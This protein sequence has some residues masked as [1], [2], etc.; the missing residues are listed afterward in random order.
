MA[1]TTATPTVAMDHSSDTVITLPKN[2]IKLLVSKMYAKKELALIDSFLTIHPHIKTRTA[3]VTPMLQSSCDRS[4]YDWEVEP[5]QYETVP[6]K[7]LGIWC[8]YLTPSQCLNYGFNELFIG[9]GSNDYINASITADTLAG[10]NTSNLMVDLDKS[11]SAIAKSIIKGTINVGY[12]FIDE[13]F[14]KGAFG[15]S[16]YDV[17]PSLASLIYSRNNNS[18]LFISSYWAPFPSICNGYS[19][20]DCSVGFQ[21]LFGL[22]SNIYVMSDDYYSD[23]CL[24]TTGYWDAFQNSYHSRNISN[25]MN[26][27][28]N[29]GSNYGYPPCS[30]PKSSDWSSLFGHANNYGMNNIWLYALQD[31]NEAAVQKF[32]YAAWTNGFV[33]NLAKQ[34]FIEYKCVDPCSSCV[35]PIKGD[36]VV[37]NMYYTGRIQ[38][39]AY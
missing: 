9:S 21:T 19:S 2:G 30:N 12:Y 39:V 6:G 5:N 8:D 31:G 26:V 23:C 36:W 15:D 32:C 35:W 25:W 17:I 4:F 14:E 20:Q 1:K 3:S 29:N 27:V 22:E 13:P 16:I 37:S 38:Y 34:F 18:K 10:F 28:I 24:T 7:Y 11:N 33:L